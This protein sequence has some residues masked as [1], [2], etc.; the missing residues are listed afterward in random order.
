MLWM[1]PKHQ[2]E[3]IS[4]RPLT[5]YYKH[6]FIRV[7]QEQLTDRHTAGYVGGTLVAS[8]RGG[9]TSYLL[10]NMQNKIFWFFTES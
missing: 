2:P 3:V 9:I 6:T 7:V 8:E 10:G 1:V 5:G 4:C